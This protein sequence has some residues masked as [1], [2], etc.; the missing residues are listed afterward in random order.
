MIREADLTVIDEAFATY[1]RALPSLWAMFSGGHDSLTATHVAAQHPRFAGVVHINTGIGIEQTR[2]FVRDTCRREGWPLREYEPPVSYDDLVMRWGFPGPGGHGL[3]YNR[4][5]E[6]CIRAHVRW[7]KDGHRRDS[8]VVLAT[9]VRSEESA[10]RMRHVQRIQKDEGRVWAAV[11]FDW[12]KIDCGRYIAA[13]DL[14]RNEVVDLLHMS[15]ECLCGAFAR[16]GE[17]EE[18][19]LWYPEVAARI[20]RLEEVAEDSGIAACRWGVR[21]PQQQLPGQQSLM[22][23]CVGCEAR[24]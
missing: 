8:L 2:E 4:L 10:R 7:V 22:P 15:G 6:R 18:V 12:T 16:P 11:I 14:P 24:A 3:I 17:L 21:P 5:K 13:H 19:A 20:R 9:G 1:P 23:L